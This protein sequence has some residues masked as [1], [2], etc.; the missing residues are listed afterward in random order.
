MST[1]AGLLEG[2]E[3]FSGGSGTIGVL[4]IHGFTSTP[5]SLRPWA[6]D[7]V[8]RGYRVEL[9]LLPGH[10]TRWEDM[11]RVTWGDWYA[12]VERAYDELA[13][14][15]EQVFVAALSMGGALALELA[16]HRTVGGLVLVNPSV[17]TRD[18]R[19]LALPLLALLRRSVAAIG[20]DIAMPDV[21][22]G[23]YERT[24]L[25]GIVQLTKLWRATRADLGKVT[26]PV[27][28]FLSQTDHVVDPSSAATILSDIGSHDVRQVMLERS[29]HVATMDYDAQE[30]FAG[31]AAFIASLVRR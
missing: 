28:L 8:A 6:D 4:L 23:A 20:S 18:K 16:A 24:P 7:L 2:A 5:R 26:A 21:V 14:Q 13:A 10:G 9:P 11:D 27:L 30:I 25:K 22:E 12:T 1:T 31:S 19:F 29:F 15:T 17:G 3:P